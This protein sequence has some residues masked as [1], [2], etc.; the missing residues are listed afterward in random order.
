M[1]E[2]FIRF[3]SANE[4]LTSLATTETEKRD[5]KQLTTST[6]WGKS[7]DFTHFFYTHTHKYLQTTL[8]I[9]ILTVE[10]VIFDHVLLEPWQQVHEGERAEHISDLSV[11]ICRVN[12]C[13]ANKD[14][15]WQGGWHVWMGVGGGGSVGEREV[16]GWQHFQVAYKH[17]QSGQ[18]ERLSANNTVIFWW[19]LIFG[20]FLLI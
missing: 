6:Q 3:S 16:S 20:F 19:L 1:I 4:F 13:T 17:T 5:D 14:R 12:K 2:S 15:F 8:N 7:T 18:C 9:F 10:H 11:R